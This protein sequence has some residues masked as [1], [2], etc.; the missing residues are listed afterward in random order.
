M[1]C[2]VIYLA[3]GLTAPCMRT[4]HEMIPYISLAVYC[5][6]CCAVFC[7]VYCTRL[8]VFVSEHNGYLVILFVSLLSETYRHVNL[9]EGSMG[10]LW[11]IWLNSLIVDCL[12]TM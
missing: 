9:A 1:V 4:Q 6:V 8:I 10:Y 7:T 12:H 2:T 3:S 5:T 11:R